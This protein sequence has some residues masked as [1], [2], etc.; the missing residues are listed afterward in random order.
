MLAARPQPAQRLLA[1]ALVLLGLGVAALAVLGPLVMGVLEYRIKDAVESQVVGGDAAGLVVVAPV[2]FVAAWL[3]LRGN[4][5]APLVALAPALY[6][7]YVVAQ[8]IVGNEWAAQ[9]GNVER[10]FPLLLAVFT[11][12]AGIGLAAW[13]SIDAESLPPLSRPASRV[14]A[15]AL[16][17]V[18]AFLVLGLHLPNY[19]GVWQGEPLPEEYLDGPTAFWVVKLMD[20]GIIVPVSLV[21]AAGLLRG[22]VL[23]RKAVFAII[24]PY[25]LL[26]TAVAGMAIMMQ[27]NDE[28]GASMAMVAAMSVFAVLFWAFAA[29]LYRPLFAGARPGRAPARA[30]AS[31][32]VR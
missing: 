27:V 8:L 17:F 4:P 5:A 20:L 11:L 30:A 10:F 24:G 2:A 31:G 28:A 23:A 18:A 26:A 32:G 1:A 14:I 13:G 16:V 25:A 19:L 21:T 29:Y 3:A 9:P 6:A 7:A 22:S 12:G 15:G